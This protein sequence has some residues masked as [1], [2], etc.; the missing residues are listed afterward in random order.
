MTVVITVQGG[1]GANSRDP[2]RY[3]QTLLSHPCCQASLQVLQSGIKGR[4]VFLPLPDHATFIQ[5]SHKGL[6]HV[7]L[8]N[9][10]PSILHH[11]SG[12]S[13]IGSIDTLC[14]VSFTYVWC[15]PDALTPINRPV[16]LHPVHCN[17]DGVTRSISSQPS[18][19]Y[20]YQ[21][22]LQRLSE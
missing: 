5:G 11:P 7:I 10:N 3:S 17:S 9:L 18:A 8:A 20:A 13:W 21:S 4:V 19:A 15:F 1:E 2:S 22:A 16:S 6:A 14:H 12:N